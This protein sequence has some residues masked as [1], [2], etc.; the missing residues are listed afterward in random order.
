VAIE[1]ALEVQNVRSVQAVNGPNGEL[2]CRIG[3][4]DHR[5]VQYKGWV[6]IEP[7]AKADVRSFCVM[8]R[9]E[10][11]NRLHKLRDV[12]DVLLIRYG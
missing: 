8:Q 4:F 1:S 9:D 2:R 11:I 3:G 12:A 7:F 6:I 10:V 5:R